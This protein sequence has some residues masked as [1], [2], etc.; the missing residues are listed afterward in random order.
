MELADVLSH[1]RRAAAPASGQSDGELLARF[2][3]SGDGAAFAALL[4]RHGPLVLSVCRRLL[5][6][7]QDAEDAFQA[8]F[9]VLVSRAGAVSNRESLGS[10]L[11]R[12]AHRTALKARAAGDRRRR[13]EAQ[14]DELP[15]PAAPPGEPRDWG[16]VYDE[17]NR[18]P[19]KYRAA[20]V[21]CDLQGHSRREAAALL[22]LP[23]GTLSSR[24]ATARRMLGERLSRRGVALEAGA[25]A[26]PA[27]VPPALASATSSL[28]ALAAAGQLAAVEAP[29]ASL[30]KGV[31]RAMLLTKV[32]VAAA[33]VL[34][35]GLAC[36]GAAFL[37]LPAPAVAQP[38][39]AGKPASEL[40]ALR[41][42][43][44]LLKVN[45]R[46]VLEKVRLQEAEIA[47]LKAAGKATSAATPLGDTTRL[48][49]PFGGGGE[50][51]T[52]PTSGALPGG[53]T[54]EPGAAAPPPGGRGNRY[55][56]A[57]PGES[58]DPPAPRKGADKRIEALEAALAAVRA[59]PDEETRAKAL[60]ALESAARALGQGP[61]LRP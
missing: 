60:K 57:M 41:K 2:A 10:W 46:V 61:G 14:V 52:R 15:H 9:L 30:A 32:K 11:Y 28:A 40:E 48:G 19:G 55:A 35:A 21:H 22:G 12:V 1:I 44:E 26:A 53:G 4:G 29:V 27:L 18:L 43:N 50:A 56:G 23:E 33:C 39:P 24:L 38:P 51:A 25:L 36:G 7:R 34:A 58:A 42:E 16:A 47:S 13:R 6:H 3:A 54:T 17:L 45:L 37:P 8:T 20:L 49:P 5:G 31:V 59:A